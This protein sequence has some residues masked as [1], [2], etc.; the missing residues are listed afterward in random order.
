[1]LVHQ[2]PDI[3][4]YLFDLCQALDHPENVLDEY[5]KEKAKRLKGNKKQFVY[6]RYY[7]KK[8]LS[9]KTNVPPQLIK[10]EVG[11]NGKPYTKDI[12]FNISHSKDHILIGI[13]AHTIGVDIESTHIK[14][15]WK[16]IAQYLFSKEELIWMNN[17][18]NRFYILWTL[19]ES[20]FKCDGVS[21][22]INNKFH[23]LEFKNDKPY[24]KNFKTDSF[25]FPDYCYSYCFK[26]D[27]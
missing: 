9:E 2:T 20:R 4:L 10:I 18:L 19:K 24:F 13:S 1:M 16:D 25:V 8:I 6:A 5:E 22:D 17:D 21:A 15:S 14:R 27:A 12:Y 26:S 7:L 11:D 3:E 23:F